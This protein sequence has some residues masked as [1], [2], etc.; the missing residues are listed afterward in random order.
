MRIAELRNKTIIYKVTRVKNETGGY[1]FVTVKQT[2]TH[3]SLED[4]LGIEFRRDDPDYREETHRATFRHRTDINKSTRLEIDGRF[5]KPVNI[6]SA[7]YGKRKFVIVDLQIEQ[8]E[9]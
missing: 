9:R 3:C 1:D 7:E 5:F 4:V 2:E 8:T 6:K